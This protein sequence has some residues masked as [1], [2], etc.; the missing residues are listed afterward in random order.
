MSQERLSKLQREFLICCHESLRNR[1]EARGKEWEE[2]LHRRQY[3]TGA[4]HAVDPDCISMNAN[5]ELKLP[6]NVIDGREIAHRVGKKMERFQ[7]GG[8]YLEPATAVS[9]SRSIR[10]LWHKGIIKPVVCSYNDV[11]IPEDNTDLYH[12]GGWGQ[13][14]E[15]NY[16]FRLFALTERGK[17]L[18][19]TVLT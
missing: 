15:K 8:P 13:I 10:N 16:Q 12:T 5:K 4:G 17:T 7:G 11:Y 19:L 2:Q 3:Y 18:M 6:D 1:E 9:I 14:Y